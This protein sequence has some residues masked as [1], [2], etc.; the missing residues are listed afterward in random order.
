MNEPG[1]EKRIF[2][3]LLEY[4]VWFFT[5]L[6]TD[7]LCWPTSGSSA[8]CPGFCFSHQPLYVSAL[9][10]CSTEERKGV[11]GCTLISWTV[12]IRFIQSRRQRQ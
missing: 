11:R 10:F 1:K 12:R 7:G 6:L 2:E 5:L 4:R 9:F 3:I 8:C